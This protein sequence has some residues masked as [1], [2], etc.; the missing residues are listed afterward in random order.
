MEPA[1]SGIYISTLVIE[2]SYFE[3][4]EP[5]RYIN[6]VKRLRLEDRVDVFLAIPSSRNSQ[7]PVYKTNI[8][9][10]WKVRE[11]DRPARDLGTLETT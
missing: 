2:L 9:T 1:D 7:I 5:W 8:R 11:Q 6:R 10:L 3:I 4:Y